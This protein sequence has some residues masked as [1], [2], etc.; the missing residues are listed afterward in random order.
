MSRA[1]IAACLAPLGLALSLSQTSF[2]GPKTYLG[3]PVEAIDIHMHPG[4]YATMGP[5][6][7][8]FVKNALPE[9]IPE[10]LKD[11]S[12]NVLSGLMLDPYGAFIGIQSECEKAGLQ[13]CGLFS[14]YAPDTWGVT[15]NDYIIKKLDDPKNRNKKGKPA[16]FGLASVRM[17]NWEMGETQQL[18]QLRQALSHPMVKG[19]KLAFIHNSIPLDEAKYNSIYQVA[20]ELDVPVYHHV[21][22]SPL[23]KLADF[24]DEEDKQEYISS[25]DPNRLEGAIAAYPN[26][27]FI[28][29]HMGFDFNKEGFDFSPTVYSLAQRY[30]NVYLEISAFGRAAYDPDGRQMDRVLKTIKDNGLIGRTVYGSDGP[31]SPGGTEKYMDA[32]LRSMERV[33]FSYAEAEDVLKNNSVRIFKL[34]NLL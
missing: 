11:V 5:L 28:L 2:A 12:L 16:F 18:T 34:E 3:M 32:T 7:K 25:Y 29:G 27:K 15:D 17:Q 33:G 4:T 31:G 20:D 24:G 9:F 1:K 14:V 19:I 13:M 6:G 10:S 26:V 30:P 8:A 21:G 23:Q 22:S